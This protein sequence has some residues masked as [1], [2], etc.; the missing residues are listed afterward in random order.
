[1]ETEVRRS[2]R[3]RQDNAGFKRNS[4]SNTKCLPCNA[5]PPIAQKTVVK[6][7]TTTFCKVADQEQAKLAKKPKKGQ[8]KRWAR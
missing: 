8:G 4:C 1:M 6:N 7:L 2:D 3:I 5:A